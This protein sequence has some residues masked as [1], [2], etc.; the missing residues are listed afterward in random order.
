MKKA[1][2]LALLAMVLVAS[3]GLAIA[4]QIALAHGGDIMAKSTLGHGSEFRVKL[5]AN[6]NITTP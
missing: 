4:R 6:P 1:L 2:S 5:P 3:L